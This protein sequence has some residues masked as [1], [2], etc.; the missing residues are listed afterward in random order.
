MAPAVAAA[1]I[2]ATGGLLQSGMQMLS[3]QR[4]NVVNARNARQAQQWELEMWNRMN[5]YNTPA[6]QIARFQAAGLN[7]HLAYSQGSAGN[8]S[9]SPGAHV[10]KT[11]GIFDNVNLTDT[12]NVL[13]AYQDY[14]LKEKQIEMLEVQNIKTQFQS[15]LERIKGDIAENEFLDQMFKYGTHMESG[16]IPTINRAEYMKRLGEIEM[17]M[18]EHGLSQTEFNTVLKGAEAEMQS[19]LKK[20]NMTNADE[21]WARL[22]VKLVNLL[23][24]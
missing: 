24:K 3:N 5:E 9:G 14:R 1:L 17:I 12:L 4:Q 19:E 10:P 23:N 20:F 6:N 13:S 15:T 8:T 21:T 11:V 22:L 2:G 16:R 7:P 18:K